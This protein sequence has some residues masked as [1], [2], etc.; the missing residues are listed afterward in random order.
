MLTNLMVTAT[1]GPVNIQIWPIYP[2]G[3]TYVVAWCILM[4][5]IFLFSHN[6]RNLQRASH[7]KFCNMWYIESILSSLTGLI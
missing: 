6:N 2:E 5:N 1:V 3:T 7:P 4:T